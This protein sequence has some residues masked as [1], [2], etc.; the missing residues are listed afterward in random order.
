MA[1]VDKNNRNGAR[2]ARVMVIQSLYAYSMIG[3]DSPETILEYR[4]SQYKEVEDFVT[5]EENL[6]PDNKIPDVDI[7]YAKQ[8]FKITIDKEKT[9]KEI[10]SR[11]LLLGWTID[12]MDSLLLSI[13]WAYVA[14][15]YYHPD[16]DNKILISE[17]IKLANGFFGDKECAFV[18][19]TVDL[20][21]LK[22]N[23]IIDELKNATE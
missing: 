21:S 1:Q 20:I 19:K 14:D 6:K 11:F 3:S 23:S 7:D 22:K 2:V 9:I 10:I 12:K 4:L 16:L 17:Y 13:I 18:N 8:L 5:K 15:I